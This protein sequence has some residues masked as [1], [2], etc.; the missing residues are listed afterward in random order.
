[1]AVEAKQCINAAKPYKH[2]HT[3]TNTINA[4]VVPSHTNTNKGFGHGKEK[5]DFY[6][7]KAGDIKRKA[8]EMQ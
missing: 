5:N 8:I 7:A 2:K 1:M 3:N 6:F 4:S